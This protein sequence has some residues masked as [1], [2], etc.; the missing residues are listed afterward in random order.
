MPI[1]TTEKSQAAIHKGAKMSEL[2]DKVVL[3]TGAGSPTGRAIC[4]AF[5][6]QGAILA[7]SDLNPLTLDETLAQVQAAG[8]RG[9]EYIFDVAKKMPVQAMFSQIIEDWGRLDILVNAISIEPQAALLDMDEWDWHRTIDVNL[10]APFLCMQQ[11]GRQMRQ[12]GGGVI[13]TIGPPIDFLDHLPGRSA[14]AAS[15]M[16]LFALSK[17]AAA[18]LAAD[19][20]RVNMICR[21]PSGGGSAENQG[22][23]MTV[24]PDQYGCPAEIPALVLHLATSAG[25]RLSGLIFRID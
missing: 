5:A 24:S 11:A 4:Q 25:A 17:T 7:A 23:M 16:A 21:A 2:T 14:Y 20:I 8:G 1:R 19:H 15:Q 6:E 9:K 12:E 22:K 18:E 13:I 10:A 3:V